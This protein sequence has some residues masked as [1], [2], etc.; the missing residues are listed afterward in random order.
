[1]RELSMHIKFRGVG[2][3][4]AGMAMAVPLFCPKNNIIIFSGKY[5]W[6]LILPFQQCR[7]EPYLVGKLPTKNN[8]TH[9]SSQGRTQGRLYRNLEGDGG[10][11][12]PRACEAHGRFA[13]NYS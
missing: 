4:T 8:R 12:Q 1:M 3:V 9:A 11:K 2:T 7:F 10:F 13:I 5:S 6:M